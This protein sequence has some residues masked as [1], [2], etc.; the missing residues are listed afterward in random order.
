MVL[1]LENN[2]FLEILL[3]RNCCTQ[4]MAES[5]VHLSNSECEATLSEKESVVKNFNLMGIK[6]D[7]N[8]QM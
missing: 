3:N 4:T 7:N 8:A 5:V 2:V 6:K 1:W